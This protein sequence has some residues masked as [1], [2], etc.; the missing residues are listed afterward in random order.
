MQLVLIVQITRFL[1]VLSRL[2]FDGQQLLQLDFV[3]LHRFFAL[4]PTDQQRKKG[5]VPPYRGIIDQLVIQKVHLGQV[6]D[7]VDIVIWFTGHGIPSETQSS[8][9]I[10]LTQVT[11]LNRREKEKRESLRG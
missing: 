8:Q 11:D 4:K 5:F 2:I 3:L 1:L 6:R 7:G 10:E 9:M